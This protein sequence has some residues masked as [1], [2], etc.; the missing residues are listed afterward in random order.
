MAF[1]ETYIRKEERTGLSY[2]NEDLYT[3]EEYEVE[4]AEKV[5]GALRHTAHFESARFLTASAN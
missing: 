1:R 3:Y 2:R 5:L 4:E